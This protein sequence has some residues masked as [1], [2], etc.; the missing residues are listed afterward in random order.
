MKGAVEALK[1][2]N[3]L[4]LKVKG[5][6]RLKWLLMKS[7]HQPLFK[8]ENDT[9]FSA[10]FIIFSHN[11]IEIHGRNHYAEFPLKGETF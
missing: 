11:F 4:I 1:M 8:N 3:R 9:R 2:V 6:I 7:I 10:V 5:L